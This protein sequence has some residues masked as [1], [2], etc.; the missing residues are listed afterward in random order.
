MLLERNEPIATAML[1]EGMARQGMVRASFGPWNVPEDVSL[2]LRSLDE[3]QSLGVSRLG[4]V[5][6]LDGT[7]LPVAPRVERCFSLDELADRSA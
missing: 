4:Y 3:I 5:P 1:P 6:K 7:W 2:L